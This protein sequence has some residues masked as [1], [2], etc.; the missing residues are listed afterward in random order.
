MPNVDTPLVR[1]RRH[2]RLP[3][4]LSNANTSPA[5]RTPPCV[6][7]AAGRRARAAHHDRG[8]R[9]RGRTRRER[10]DARGLGADGPL[11]LDHLVH[12]TRSAQPRDRPLYRTHALSNESTP[13]LYFPLKSTPP[14]LTPTR[15]SLTQTT[16]AR[17]P[18]TNRRPPPV[19][20]TE[21]CTVAAGSG[22]GIISW[23]LGGGFVVG[24]LV[25]F[26]YVRR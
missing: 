6:A 24:V 20:V 2:P 17:P 9:R 15:P 22:S 3:R 12:L 10:L 23:T 7:S 26:F 4:P 16:Q 8:L 13:S 11:L 1:E 19:P 25:L 14:S 21:S 5:S 18:P